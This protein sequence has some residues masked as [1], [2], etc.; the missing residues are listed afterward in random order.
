MVF[1]LFKRKDDSQTREALKPSKLRLRDRVAS[2][3]S[4]AKALDEETLEELEY[5]L[6]SADL[7]PLMTDQ[8]LKSLK[9]RYENELVLDHNQLMTRLQLSLI[10]QFEGTIEPQPLRNEDGL[11]VTLI[12]G[13]NGSGKTTSIAKLA[14]AWTHEGRKVVL[15]AGDTFRAAAS[16][17][18]ATWAER[19]GVRVVKHH[20]GADPSALVYD[21]LSAAESDQADDLIIDTAGRLHTDSNLMKELEKIR[22]IIEKKIPGAPHETLLVLDATAGQNALA[23]A[24]LFSEKVP[25]T[26]LVLAKL[27]GTA[28]GGIIFSIAKEAGVPVKYVGTGEQPEN[29]ELF[30]IDTFVEA[31]VQ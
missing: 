14:A 6:V 5:I 8:V 15:G 22:R 18:L 24:Q 31:L 12:V 28:R 27:D 2:L 9:K 7:G 19:L 25:L 20:E 1:R 4:S 13:V 11:T 16:A 17:Q 26:G 21:A 29:L 30:N 10:E 23:Q 3:F